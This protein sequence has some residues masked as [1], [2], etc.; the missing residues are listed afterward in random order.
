MK[1]KHFEFLLKKVTE[2][3]GDS[4]KHLLTMYS[5]ALSINAKNIL[6]LGV[7]NGDTTLPY[8]LAAKENDGYLESVDVNESAFECP[9]ELKNLWSFYKTDAIEFLQDKV[10][11]NKKYDLI[12][13]DDWHSYEHVKKELELIDQ[14]IR[15]GSVVLLHDL[16]YGNTCPYY[17]VDLTACSPQW[18]N[19]GPYRAVAELNPNF[20]EFST[21]PSNNGLTILRK[22]Y[23]SKY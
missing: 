14:L 6:E 13:I 11:E 1:N 22:K 21:I 15:P 7:R 23:S 10:L 12:Y 5:I 18:A 4:D 17:H 19:G 16:M 8:L 2:G 20:W 9:I 3:K